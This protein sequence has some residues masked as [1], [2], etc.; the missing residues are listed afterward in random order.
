MTIEALAA[1]GLGAIEPGAL[2]SASALR[3][4]SAAPDTA[5][6][7][8]LGSLEQL[9]SQMQVNDQSIQQLALGG[10]DN[11]HQVMM[12]LERTRLAFELA[13]QVRNKALEAYQE[14]MR[15]QV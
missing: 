15:M 13:L 5:F 3:S 4:T 8:M 10:T 1:L 11:L 6:D 12:T 9:N 14:L 7:T 2:N